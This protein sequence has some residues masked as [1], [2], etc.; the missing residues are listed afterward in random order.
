[1]NRP[2]ASQIF[3]TLDATWPAAQYVHVD[4]WT[5]RVGLGGGK[6]VSAATLNNNSNATNIKPAVDEIRKYG[7]HPLFMVRT[8]DQMLDMTL[9]NLGYELI[10]PVT[11]FGIQPRKLALALEPA[12]SLP[13]WPPLA[14]QRELWR[15]GGVDES[16]IAIMA[17]AKQPKVSILG[18][19]GDVPGGTAFAAV[20]S[21]IAMVHAI[22]V[23][24]SERRKGVGRNLLHATANWALR[25]GAAWLTLAVT[26]SNEPANKLYR[27]LGMEPLADYH[28]R[29][30][31]ADPA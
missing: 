3:K 27:A 19:S 22:E 4:P 18:R 20:N 10:D 15:M 8:E 14:V 31:P 30:A 9:S 6:R 28:Y 26:K 24:V 25:Q 7:Q 13:C 21:G 5:V 23:T 2:S 29:Q 16:R 17:R 12:V 11:V 1:M